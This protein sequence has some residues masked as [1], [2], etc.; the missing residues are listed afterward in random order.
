LAGFFIS[1]QMLRICSDGL[2][3]RRRFSERPLWR[4]GGAAP[5]PDVQ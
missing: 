3:P 4:R 2:S 1:E 5:S